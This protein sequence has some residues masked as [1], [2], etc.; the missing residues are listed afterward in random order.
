[1]SEFGITEPAARGMFIAQAGHES[2]EFT[3]TAENFNYSVPGLNAFIRAGRISAEQAR[4]LGRQPGEK[5]MPQE[6]QRATA[7]LVYGGRLG[8]KS[9]GD[10]FWSKAAAKLIFTKNGETMEIPRHLSLPEFSIQGPVL[11][12]VLKEIKEA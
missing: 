12:P 7:N 2:V 9:A 11:N 8:N 3:R 6:R 5:M 1:M 4:M 10:C